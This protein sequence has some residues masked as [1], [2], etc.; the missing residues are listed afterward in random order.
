MHSAVAAIKESYF[1]NAHFYYQWNQMER[2]KVVNWTTTRKQY[3][4]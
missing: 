4:I 3:R 2:N 1:W